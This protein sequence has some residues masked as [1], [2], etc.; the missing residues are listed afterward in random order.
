MT[1]P[2]FG[3]IEL[4][5]ARRQGRNFLIVVFLFSIFVNLLMLVGPLFM[6][7]VYD[8]VLASQS[9]STLVALFVLVAALYGLMALLDFAR[10]RLLGRFGAR[11][12][13]ALD[14]RVFRA[15]LG[16]AVMARERSASSTGLRDL[17]QMGSIMGSP[18]MLAFFDMPWCPIFFAALFIFHPF[19]GWLGLFGGVILVIITLC[20]Q[21]LTNWR[22][23]EAKQASGNAAYLAEQARKFGEDVRAQGMTGSLAERWQAQR[24]DAQ[25]LDVKYNDITGFFSSF[26]K[27]FRLFLQSTMLAAGA[28]LVLQGQLTAGA[29]IAGTI[30]LGRALAPIEQS[31]GQWKM[32]QTAYS[33]WKSLTVLLETTA[34]VPEMTNLPRPDGTITVKDLVVQPFGAK[35]PTL[36]NVSFQL[37]PGE[38]LGVVGRSGIGKSSLVR[39]LV[40]VLPPRQG[41]IRLGG[42]ELSQYDPDVLGS[43]IGYLPQEVTFFNGTIAENIARMSQSP[44]S[45]EV[46]RAAKAALAHDLILTLPKGYDTPVLGGDIQLSGG[47]KQRVALA[48]ALYGNPEVLILDEPNSALD[49]DGTQALSS[50]VKKMKENK[51]SV[52][53]TTHRPAGLSE[54]DFLMFLNQGTVMAFGPRDE[55]LKKLMS[56]LNAVNTQIQE[57][58]KNVTQK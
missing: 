7:Q 49:I 5:A 3:K 8:R 10:G 37:K 45:V 50:V 28:W 22:M 30:I 2:V 53:V 48:R 40:G 52:I 44:D 6:L 20:N 56:G 35:K 34:P 55:V 57:A 12:Q 46:V 39:S 15:V 19:L 1:S 4:V 24:Q 17:E 14:D 23:K 54:A 38:V 42:A 16:R 13:E 25:N 27:S 33:G 18:P 58:R 11:F 31:I 47:Q 9:E 43:Y 41:E 21:F 51:K 26:T 32:F 29:M 36:V